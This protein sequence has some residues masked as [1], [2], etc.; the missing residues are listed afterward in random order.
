M[1]IPLMRPNNKPDYAFDFNGEDNAVVFDE[2]LIG[3]QAINF[4]AYGVENITNNAYSVFFDSGAKNK[5]TK[6]VG[7]FHHRTVGFRLFVSGNGRR[8]IFH[9]GGFLQEYVSVLN[10]QWSGIS[11]D[12]ATLNID[13]QTFNKIITNDYDGESTSN[14]NFFKPYYSVSSR[15]KGVTAGFEF[16]GKIFELNEGSGHQIKDRVSGQM[17]DITGT[18]NQEQWIKL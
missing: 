4:T 17:Y 1:M 16:N 10:F 18:V 12:T 3:K 2:K 6:G 11:G 15:F 9:I 13:G 7:L 14:I 8:D 5:Y